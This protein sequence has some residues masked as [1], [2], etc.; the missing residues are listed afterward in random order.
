MSSQHHI[1]RRQYFHVEVF[2]TES[3]GWT[4][5]RRLPELCLDSL[6]PAL[7][8][9]LEHLV[10][11]HEHLTIERLDIDVGTLSLENIERGLADAVVQAMEKWLCAQTSPMGDA[12]GLSGPIQRKTESRSTHEAF[13]HFLVTG[14]LPWW[15][16]L[17]HGK[18]LE[19][20]ILSSWQNAGIAA[21][22]S[23][24]FRRSM[25]D[26]IGSAFVRQRLVQQFS[27]NFLK[28][29][30]ARLSPEDSKTLEICANMGW[31]EDVS[32]PLRRFS[33]QLWQTAF[34]KVAMGE[35]VTAAAL[36]SE[37]WNALPH[38]ERQDPVLR[39]QM[40]Q[41]WPDILQT[42]K[43]K[44]AVESNYRKHRKSAGQQSQASSASQHFAAGM[45]VQANAQEASESVKI[46]EAI[47]HIDLMGGVY[48]P[49]AGLVLLHPFL[50]R[51]FEALGIATEDRLLNPE[52]ALCLLHFL[53]T[54]QRFAPEYELLLPK[55]LCNVPLEAPVESEV[56][57][58]TAE[59]EET[60][61]L[62]AAVVRHWDAL[63]NTSAD[64][65]R[66]TF[67]VRPGKLSKREDG[68]YLLHVEN[69]SFDILLDQ[70]PWGIST[71][72]LPWMDKLLW[73]EWR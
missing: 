39:E 8:S 3:D 9:M 18:T 1:I 10:S 24:Y 69:Q 13:L 68:D 26:A 38:A 70:L 36:V 35:P 57:L 66:G 49:C 71:I 73:V 21:S 32:A 22:G 15:F 56:E 33:R 62:L 23:A 34:A 55:L 61:A 19:Q 53:A 51:F 17:P 54:G 29:L 11:P 5:Q 7:E 50:P 4:L 63:R 44:D 41:H 64:G 67:L 47:E 42:G 58:T 30:L 60:A 48:V 27:A 37:S 43:I 6:M 46:D 45:E 25:I 59:E 31:Q 40:K 72:K 12:T 2:G 52:R 28:N 14:S 16:H 65:L 20:V